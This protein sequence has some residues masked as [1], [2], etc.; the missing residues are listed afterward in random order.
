LITYKQKVLK[1]IFV[2]TRLGYFQDALDGFGDHVANCDGIIE[3]KGYKYL[4][5]TFSFILF[6]DEDSKSDIKDSQVKVIGKQARIQFKLT[7]GIGI[8]LE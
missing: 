8:K 7:I 2:G 4:S 1:N 6:Y 3:L 5:T